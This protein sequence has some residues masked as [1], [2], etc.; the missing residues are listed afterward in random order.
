MRSPN[1]TKMRSKRDLQGLLKVILNTEDPVSRGSAIEAGIDLALE[2]VYDTQQN[3]AWSQGL[4]SGLAVT[5]N[6]GDDLS[7]ETLL[8]II[9]REF[10][11][12]GNFYADTLRTS[13]MEAIRGVGAAIPRLTPLLEHPDPLV[14]IDAA[15]TIGK[16]G[17]DTGDVS[18]LPALA[19]TGLDAEPPPP[20]NKWAKRPPGPPYSWDIRNECFIAAKN[21]ERTNPQGYQKALQAMSDDERAWLSAPPASG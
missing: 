7:L 11:E 13:A 8:R 9:G 18:A 5:A 1:V 10:G 4:T 20:A 3:I 19:R 21:I 17:F 16:I 14:R 12:A 15:R 2:D 6:R